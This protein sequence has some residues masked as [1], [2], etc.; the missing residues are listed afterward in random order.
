VQATVSIE[1]K[2]GQ[3]HGLKMSCADCRNMKAFGK[4]PAYLIPKLQEKIF[5]QTLL[6]AVPDLA[7][8]S[9]KR[10]LA[11]ALVQPT[12]AAKLGL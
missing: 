3:L 8:M 9:I 5:K 6:L 1:V 10:G 2:N 12:K 11:G 4:Q 7:E